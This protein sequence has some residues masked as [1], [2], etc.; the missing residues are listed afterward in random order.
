MR[1][2]CLQFNPVL[3]DVDG[4]IARA[5][6]LLQTAMAQDLHLDLLMLPELAFSG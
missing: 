5:E 3:G 6:A 4:N 2:S 1:I